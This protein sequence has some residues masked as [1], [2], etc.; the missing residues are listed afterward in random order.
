MSFLKIK[1]RVFFSFRTQLEAG[2]RLSKV[3][4]GAQ[5]LKRLAVNTLQP[6][7]MADFQVVFI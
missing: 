1:L 6:I 2:A 4:L 7:K 5:L 3:R